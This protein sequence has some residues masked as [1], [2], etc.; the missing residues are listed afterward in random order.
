M[1]T[2]E[3]KQ[4]EKAINRLGDCFTINIDSF[5]EA[6]ALIKGDEDYFIHMNNKP[7]NCDPAREDCS[8]SSYLISNSPYINLKL[9]TN[10]DEDKCIRA[11]L[12]NSTEGELSGSIG[13]LSHNNNWWLS[14]GDYSLK[15]S[16]IMSNIF[17]ERVT[18][19]I[20]FSDYSPTPI[21]GGLTIDSIGLLGFS[22]GYKNLYR[23]LTNF[24]TPANTLTDNI[25]DYSN[26]KLLE[27][28]LVWEKQIDEQCNIRI[29]YTY[30]YFNDK[31]GQVGSIEKDILSTTSIAI[32]YS[33]R[34]NLNFKLSYLN[35]ETP[36]VKL[37]K[38]EINKTLGDGQPY[39]SGI[40]NINLL[41]LSGKTQLSKSVLLSGGLGRNTNDDSKYYKLV[42]SKLLFKNTILD[43][44]LGHIDGDGLNGINKDITTLKSK[45]Y[46]NY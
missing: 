37:I 5:V 10:I 24:N 1:T 19:S 13:I 27:G 16:C 33:P 46:I 7:I 34:D 26:I 35:G 40:S 38:D 15:S 43:L 21:S 2:I 25:Q 45:I 14:V 22:I 42:L 12:K 29:G 39:I 31:S 41:A 11:S 30:N 8:H 20:G 4:L 36:D 44:E 3:T 23:P 32:K 18:N 6:R 28:T 17:P 9:T